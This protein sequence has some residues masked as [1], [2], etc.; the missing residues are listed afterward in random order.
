MSKYKICFP[1]TVAIFLSFPSLEVPAPHELKTCLSSGLSRFPSEAT[2]IVISDSC[3]S[4]TGHDYPVALV[5]FHVQ[6]M[7]RD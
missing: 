6:A 7:T 3:R 5:H 4:W 1:N 2:E